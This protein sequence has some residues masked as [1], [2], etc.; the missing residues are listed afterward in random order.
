MEYG[1]DSLVGIMLEFV[2]AAVL[3]REPIIPQ[4][5]MIDW[6]RLMDL[7]V[8][9][10]LLALVFNGICKLSES[11]QPNRNQRIN[12]GLSAE[13]TYR[14]FNSQAKVLKK[15]L[16]T[17]E[18]NGMRLL[19]LKGIS[20]SSLYPHPQE[21]SCSDI[22]I[23]LFND[24]EK[25]NQIWSSCLIKEIGKH[26]T[27]NIDNVIVE[28]HNNFLEPNTRQKRKI[29]KYLYSSLDK[30][31]LSDDGYYVLDP[32]A[33]F[34]FLIFH[35]LKHFYG[36]TMIPI[37]NILDLALFIRTNS[38]CLIPSQCNKLLKQMHLEKSFEMLLCLSE[39]ILDLDIPNYHFQ[40]L[41]S[42][43]LRLMKSELYSD[44]NRSVE[45]GGDKMTIAQRKKSLSKLI[46]SKYVPRNNSYKQIY[47]SEIISWLKKLKYFPYSQIQHSGIVLEEHHYCDK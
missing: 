17:C 29:I 18:Q 7:S 13:E 32:L 4:D 23:F 41:P 42:G 34:L 27:L 11:C 14:T 46:V 9:Q 8:E 21:R 45:K 5:T 35:A 43:D 28:S 24:Y 1:E 33:N 2:R 36:G 26:S 44:A 25:G 6:D 10:D 3:E 37:R 20:L 30:V 19:L 38:D 31:V 39:W 47:M 15:I 40:K 12:W 16:N 22:D